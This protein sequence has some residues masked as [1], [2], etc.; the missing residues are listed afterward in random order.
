[1][2]AIAGP[3]GTGKSTVSD[4]LCAKL[5]ET[6]REATVLPMDGFHLDNRLLDQRDLRHRKGAP[7]TFDVD[8][9]CALIER[10]SNGKEVIYPVFDRNRDIAIAGAGFV[11]SDTEFVIVEGNYLLFDQ[12]SWITLPQFWSYSVW[13]STSKQELTNRLLARWLAEGLSKEQAL[14][15]VRQNDLANADLVLSNRLPADLEL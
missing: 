12:P 8:G 13:I 1:M 7:E 6:D 5:N 15:K 2:I 9:F 4:A 11:A 14:K 10:V 3:P